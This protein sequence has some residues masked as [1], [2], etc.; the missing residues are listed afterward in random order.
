MTYGPLLH[1]L[2]GRARQ[3]GLLDGN[4]RLGA[5]PQRRAEPHGRGSHV[6][7]VAV[8]GSTCKD[9][10]TF[11]CLVQCGREVPIL[12]TFVKSLSRVLNL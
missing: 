5:Q 10:S 12:K 6:L 4:T 7:R 1:S 2:R 11:G 9:I 8:A 3:L